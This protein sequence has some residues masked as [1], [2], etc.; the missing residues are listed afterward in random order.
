MEKNLD[1]YMKKS[2][3]YVVFQDSYGDGNTCYVAMH[4]DLDGCMSHGDTIDQA[5]SSL[6]DARAEYLKA[7]IETKQEIP[8]PSEIG[9]VTTSFSTIP[10]DIISFNSE[11]YDLVNYRIKVET[12]LPLESVV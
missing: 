12:T 3:P 1:F 6:E 9:S 7:L 2:F 4:P 8:E 5:I 11:P 10:T